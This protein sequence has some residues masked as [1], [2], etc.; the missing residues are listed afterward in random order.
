MGFTVVHQGET[1]D[2]TYRDY[3]LH[4]SR[5]LLKRGVP[6]DRVPRTGDN[7]HAERWL[8]VWD[9]EDEARAFA[10]ELKERTEDPGWAVCPAEGPVSVGP[11]R[12]LV[13]EVGR[14]VSSWTFG[15]NS[16][17]RAALRARFPG[18]CQNND[19]SIGIPF[20][21]EKKV[22]WPA[23]VAGVRGTIAH[24]LP[25]LTGL[26]AEQLQP[27]GSYELVDPVTLQVIVPPT[28]IQPD[29]GAAEAGGLSSPAPATSGAA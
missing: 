8:Y 7:G 1:T 21:P 24:V 5:V 3:L 10:E 23:T 17:T 22:D 27:F 4:Q 16:L 26:R 15:L 12:P 11:L 19:V 18:S 20:L 25:L 29:E 2:A 28:P 13:I 6:L 9:R 14:E